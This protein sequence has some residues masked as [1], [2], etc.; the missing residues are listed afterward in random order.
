MAPASAS[1]ATKT[2][3]H[4]IGGA[5]GINSGGLFTQPLDIA[6]WQGAN[7]VDYADD[8]IFTIEALGS[9]TRV[10]RLDV[11]GNFERAWGKDAVTAGGSGDTPDDGFEICT[12]AAECDDTMVG[13]LKGEMSLPSGIAVDQADGS[14]YVWDR[15]N[16][17]IQKFSPDGDFVAMFGR[18]V[19]QTAIDAAAP[20][21]QRDVCTQASGDTCR[22]GVPGSAAGQLGDTSGQPK[23]EVNP[24]DRHVI[25]ADPQNRRV[26][27]YDAGGTFVRAWGWGV[28]TGADQFEVCT[29][30][31]T[32]QA[33]STAAGTQNGR[34][35]SSQPQHV[36]VDSSGIVYASDT[37][38]DSRVLRFDSTQAA[39][40][41][42]LETSIDATPAGGP[43]LV[44]RTS[45]TSGQLEIDRDDDGAGADEE[46]LLVL[47]DPSVGDTVVQEL[48]ISAPATGPVTTEIDRHVF[49]P[50][51]AN[52]G[53]AVAGPD[54]RLLLPFSDNGDAFTACDCGFSAGFIVLADP[55]GEA[56][57]G[58]ITAT[59]SAATTATVRGLVTPNGL[60]SFRL[61]YS[62]DGIEWRSAPVRYAAGSEER[63]V[64]ASLTG[65]TPNTTYRVRM[66]RTRYTSLTTAETATSAESTFL[67][68]AVPPEATTH[69]AV[70]VRSTSAVLQGTVNPNGSPTEY[71]FEYGPSST[72]GTRS[73]SS[74]AS[75]GAGMARTVSASL[76]GL[77]PDT[78]YHFRVVAENPLGRVEGGD[79]A[80]RTRP[81][82]TSPA[83][84]AYELV[85][86]ADKIGGTGVSQWYTGP[87]EGSS[88]GVAADEGDR[89]AVRATLGSMLVDGAFA[90]ADDTALAE[91]TTSGWISQPAA[92]RGGYGPQET[93]FMAVSAASDDLSLMLFTSNGG[94]LRLFPELESWDENEN[95]GVTF[96][97]EWASGRWEPFGPTTSDQVRDIQAGSDGMDENRVA[98]AG[99]HALGAGRLRGLAG[100]GDPTSPV[101]PDLVAGS[102]SVY[103]DDVSAGLSDTFPGKGR[104]S[105]VN[106]CTPGTE[107]PVRT[108]SGGAF[109]LT[110]QP[111]PAA[112]PGRDAH[113]ISPLGAWLGPN[114]IEA[115]NQISADGSRIFF[116]SPGEAPGRQVGQCSGTGEATTCPAQ[117]YVRAVQ[118][119]G[120][121]LTRWVSRSEV[122][123]QEA[124]LAARVTFQGATPDGDKVFFRTAAPLTADDPNGGL[125]VPGGVKSGMPHPD[126]MDL[127]MYD[128]PDGASADPAD[129]HLVRI[130]AGPAGVADGN[131]AASENDL[132][133]RHA[134]DDGQ[135]VYFTSAAPLSGVPAASEGLTEPGGSPA[136]T[137]LTNLYLYDGRRE[138]AQRWSFVARLPRSSALGACATMHGLSGGGGLA[139]QAGPD[140]GLRQKATCVSGSAD[141]AFLTFWT[142]G[143]LTAD[144][145][146]EE[147]GDIYGYDAESGELARITAPQGGAGGPYDCVTHGHASGTRCFGDGGIASQVGVPA[148]PADPRDRI[149]FFQSRTRLV[150]EDRDDA[151]DVYEWRNGELSLVSTGASDTDGAMYR[152]T[153]RT[154]RNVY[155]I[156]R[157]RLTWQD[158]DA[159][160]DV[161][162]ARVGGGIPQPPRPSVCDVLAGACHGVGASPV[163]VPPA[164]T[165]PPR[166][167]GNAALGERQ[168]LQFGKLGRKARRL[169]SRRGVLAL[170]VRAAGAGRLHVVARGRLAGRRVRKLGS[171]SRTVREAGTTRVRLRLDRRARRW[172]D[173]GRAIRLTLRVSQAGARAR[174]MSVRLPGVPS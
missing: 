100:P 65:L 156:T 60:W 110:A 75:A 8:K 163:D 54:R 84:R 170:R 128:L 138:P 140:I 132:A 86:P 70:N 13:S 147:T 153:D 4:F 55:A 24:V 122:S 74:G 72:Y 109:V 146:D 76:T 33:G 149:A 139:G 20:Q 145:P 168:A 135:R 102:P 41:D 166:P 68:D 64:T 34:F 19:N 3:Q 36:A 137:E 39:P 12:V 97:R 29:T 25:V 17:R 90:F 133:V 167:S 56:E 18:D 123:G 71:Y 21:A 125:P 134:S 144:D 143:R 45:A 49:A 129:G 136:S 38:V 162:A 43:L 164:E 130:S 92:N 16:F 48:A 5:A 31:S 108:E 103:V 79:V 169:A 37:N 107:I 174:S 83:S 88:A 112:L 27:E 59:E 99:R 148:R 30:A 160:L 89:F 44:A 6:V 119:D 113:L 7:P 96:L 1:A 26:A 9:S 51:A 98:G 53:I 111:C 77:A 161:Y 11:D 141:G 158:H 73:P 67:T 50:R 142:D 14:V 95:G 116:A 121:V 157:D 105:L 117:L 10:Q 124:S 165:V 22:A 155:F 171:A 46:T 61:Q 62:S 127:Y 151:Y 172:L 87:S 58:S 115:P 80:F 118:P 114:D 2:M 101:F 42:M 104:R 28:D 152:A 85:S 52:G 81:L 57:F 66:L 120:D 93:R 82:P 91:R 131:V 78:V 173:D 154:G 159:V 69:A 15:S 126:S 63:V 47:R 106:V 94:T 40:A 23:L 35:E 150:R 32:C